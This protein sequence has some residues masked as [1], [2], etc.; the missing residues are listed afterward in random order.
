[1]EA[2]GAGRGEVEAMVVVKGQVRMGLE[3]WWRWDGA[4]KAGGNEGRRVRVRVRV[5]LERWWKWGDAGKGGSGPVEWW[6]LSRKLLLYLFLC[7]M[8]RSPSGEGFFFANGS[9]LEPQANR[10]IERLFFNLC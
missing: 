10:L 5:G 9:D 3:Q 4:G 1:M 6:C 7:S 2:G 8:N